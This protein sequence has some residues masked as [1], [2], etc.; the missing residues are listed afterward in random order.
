MHKHFP[1]YIL[2]ASLQD[3]FLS[4]NFQEHQLLK[5]WLLRDEA[6]QI[7]NWRPRTNTV[8]LFPAS[9]LCWLFLCF[10]TSNGEVTFICE[11]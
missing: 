6:E 10:T 8:I 9:D 7:N 1:K 5:V 3:S 4:N 11:E 2:N